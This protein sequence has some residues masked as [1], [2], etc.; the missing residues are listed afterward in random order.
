M[1]FFVPEALNIARVAGEFFDPATAGFG[2][3]FIVNYVNQYH[4]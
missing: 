4:L 3:L 2:C 1:S